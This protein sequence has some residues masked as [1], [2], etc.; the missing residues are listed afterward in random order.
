MTLLILALCNVLIIGN[1]SGFNVFCIMINPRNIRSLST[2]INK[3]TLLF[4][5]LILTTLCILHNRE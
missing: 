5:R 4:L 1:V 2:W 3:K